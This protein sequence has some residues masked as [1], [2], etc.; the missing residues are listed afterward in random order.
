[1]VKENDV[2]LQEVYAQFSDADGG[3]DKGTQHSYIDIYAAE[4]EK[5][6]GISLLEIGV[7][8]GHSIAMWQSYFKDSEIL[9]VDITD[10][11]VKFDI[12]LLVADA[13]KPIPE[14]AGKQFDY[15]IDDGSHM[16]ADQI[17]SFELLWGNLK[18]G[19]KYFIED[20]FGSQELIQIEAE[21]TKLGLTFR[22]YDCRTYKQRF[23]DILLVVDKE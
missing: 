8:E 1:M 11:K 22:V 20:I 13:T 15:I 19:G 10:E 4:M 6:E 21:F 12:P 17:A 9:G 3:G 14:L 2:R 18:Q 23:D 5:T 7:W 16:V